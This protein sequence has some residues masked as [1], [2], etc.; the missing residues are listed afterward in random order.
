MLA[1]ARSLSYSTCAPVH[2]A[3]CLCIAL[4][5]IV[6]HSLHLH[7]FSAH[8]IAPK[9]VNTL[10]RMASY[11]NIM[12]RSLFDYLSNERRWISAFAQFATTILFYSLLVFPYSVRTIR[13]AWQTIGNCGGG[14]GGWEIFSTPERQSSFILYYYSFKIQLHHTHW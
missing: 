4:H 14:G 2:Y 11:A 3:Y 7:F 9:K 10:R 8:C 1:R 5:R 6:R 12:T 13:R